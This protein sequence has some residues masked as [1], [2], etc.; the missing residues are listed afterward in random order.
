M[1]EK[2]EQNTIERILQDFIQE[3][4]HSDLS[5]QMLSIYEELGIEP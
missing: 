4:Q 2:R 1:H 5:R 3:V